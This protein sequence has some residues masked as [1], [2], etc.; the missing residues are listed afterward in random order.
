MTGPPIPGTHDKGSLGRAVALQSDGKIVVVGKVTN[1]NG[2][3]R[4]GLLIE[5]YDSRG[6]LDHS[7]GR[8]G[9]VDVL[10]NSFYGDG[11][12]VAIQ[13]DGGIVAAGTSDRSGAGG[14]VPRTAVVRVKRNGS[15][16]GSFGQRGIAAI[17]LGT[18]SYALSLALQR[19]GK[20]VLAG[21]TAPGVQVPL[22][23]VARLT[24]S[25][26]LDRSFARRG[27]FT[28]QYA[29]SASDSSFNAVA[30]QRDGK[31]VATG[32]AADGNNG[33]DAIVARFAGSGGQDRCFGS[34]GSRLHHLGDELPG[35]RDL[36]PGCERRRP[37]RRRQDHRRG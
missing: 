1:G 20:I 26:A 15:L 18:Y 4:D 7:F 34:G 30:V 33:A 14:V 23:M 19:N 6:R 9:I 10:T 13:P 24:G 32:S 29:R 31:I 35:N 37:R 11:Y 3:A 36:D 27:E 17:D 2:L 5:R 22:A 12:G 21:S 28:H 8:A 25:G 16:D